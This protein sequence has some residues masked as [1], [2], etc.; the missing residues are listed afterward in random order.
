MS[1]RV[2]FVFF[3]NET[4]RT[5]EKS[6]RTGRGGAAGLQREEVRHI[7]GERLV[8]SFGRKATL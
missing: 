8:R 1:D 4:E 5:S 7:S 6:R 2:A 3:A